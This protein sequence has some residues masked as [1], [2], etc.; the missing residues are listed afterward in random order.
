[1]HE[2]QGV[3]F[4]GEEEQISYTGNRTDEFQVYIAKNPM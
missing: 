2:Y 4:R 1:M 3:L